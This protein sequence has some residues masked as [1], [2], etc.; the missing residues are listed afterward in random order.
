VR[1]AGLRSPRRRA[2]SIEIEAIQRKR[3]LAAAV[4]AVQDGGYAGFTVAQ[5]TARARVSRKTFYDLFSDREDCFLA[6]FEQTI[7]RARLLA[8][9]AYAQA[10]GWRE[11]V[12]AALATILEL[13]QREPSL[14]KLCIAETLGAGEAVRSRRAEVLRELAEVID[15]GR[16]LGA[17]AREPPAVTAEGVVGGIDTV[18][19]TRLLAANAGEPTFTDLLGPFMSMV[20]LPYLGSRA[21]SRE[22]KRPAPKLAPARPVRA[23]ADSEDPFHGLN[24]RMTYRTA[25]VLAVI[26]ERPGINNREVA[27]GAGVV[28]QGQISKLLSRLAGL[29]LIENRGL[30]VNEG[31]PNCWWLTRR[32]QQIERISRVRP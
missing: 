30:G 5:V 19:H 9:A 27:A 32:G 6:A 28:D 24:M 7:E 22:L 26:A 15:R 16:L 31:A 3:M 17:A 25:Q 21:A 2:R 20:V 13:M 12:R 11:G 8:V 18:L 14:A 23:L 4:E 29:Q 10:P 1:G